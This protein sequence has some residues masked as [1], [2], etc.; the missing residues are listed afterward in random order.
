MGREGLEGADMPIDDPGK[1][2]GRGQLC[3]DGGKWT[4]S[5]VGRSPRLQVDEPR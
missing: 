5:L 3:S 1:E 2:L 4:L